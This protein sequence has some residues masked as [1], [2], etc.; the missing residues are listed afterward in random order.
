MT[1]ML[2]NK[3]IVHGDP[4]EFEA[5]SGSLTE[6]MCRQPGYLRFQLLRSLRQPQAYVEIAEWESAEQHR[7]AVT[8]PGFRERVQPLAAVAS[9]EPD[10]YAVVR[11][12]HA[13]AAPA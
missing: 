7:A 4:A 2:V 12:G 11:E 10:L 8:S 6:Y 1:V 9:V 13:A 3:L 5:I